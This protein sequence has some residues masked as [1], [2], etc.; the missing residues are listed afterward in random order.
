MVEQAFLE[1]KKHIESMY[2]GICTITERRKIEREDGSTGLEDVPVFADQPCKVSYKSIPAASPGGVNASLTQQIKL[3]L[4]PTISVKPGSKI[5][6]TQNGIMTEYKSS[7][8]PAVYRTHQE[9]VLE[10]KKERA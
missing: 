2:E 9:V 6:V 4:D 7:G 5:T 1:V 10:L 3:F 8:Q